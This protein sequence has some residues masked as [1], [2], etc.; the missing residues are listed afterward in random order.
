MDTHGLCEILLAGDNSKDLELPLVALSKHNVAN[1]L[2]VVRDGAAALDYLYREGDFA[3]RN[4]GNPAA[5]LLDLK[6]PKVDGMDVLRKVKSD[7]NLKTIPIVILTSS[8]EERDL[9]D[10]YGLGANA[11]VVKPVR[12]NDFVEA[13]SLL[14]MFWALINEPPLRLTAPR[15]KETKPNH[16]VVAGLTDRGFEEGRRADR[17][18]PGEGWLRRGFATG[19]GRS[20]GSR[21]VG[22]ESLGHCHLRSRY[23]LIRRAG[24]VGNTP[25]HRAGRSVHRRFGR[26]RRRHRGTDAEVRRTTI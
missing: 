7:P 25:R 17:L 4:G 22:A 13:V 24:G 3:G 16:A 12:F 8:R 20:S 23:A 5:V 19:A 18:P 14:G 26:D 10:G 9:V 6:M 21:R 11:Y 1:Q 2:V 15:E